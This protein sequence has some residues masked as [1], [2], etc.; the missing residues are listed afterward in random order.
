MGL[1]NGVVA[2]LV[3]VTLAIAMRRFGWNSFIGL[4]LAGASLYS[5]P[6]IIGFYAPLQHSLGERGIFAPTSAA[7][8]TLMAMVWMIFLFIVATL[9][10]PRS[11]PE[12]RMSHAGLHLRSCAILTVLGYLAVAMGQGL[13]FF[14][15]A[16]HEITLGLAATLW[17]WLPALGLVIAIASR[18][19]GYFSFFSFFLLIYFIAG[20]RTIPAIVTASSILVLFVKS[21]ER[22]SF[23]RPATLLVIS[24]LMAG[25]IFGKPIYLFIKNPSAEAMQVLF[26]AEMLRG[27][28]M[29]FEPLGT[30][31]LLEVALDARLQMDVSLFLLSI[32]GNA[33]MMPSLFGVNTNYFNEFITQSMPSGLTFGVAG[34]FFASAYVGLG[35]AGV[36]MLAVLFL[37]ALSVAERHA[38]RATGLTRIFLVVAGATLAIYAHRNGVDNVLSFL[39]QIII[40]TLAVAVVSKAQ[41]AVLPF[42]AP[43]PRVTR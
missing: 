29:A 30:Y 41:R 27:A 40:A 42:K 33:L 36:A 3:A 11:Y 8:V 32:F 31:S 13:L 1:Q 22:K 12:R 21:G 9:P 38:L 15:D 5:L 43:P 18:R 7:S 28:L 20:D 19:W 25:L 6:A 39:R 16:R 24:L 17:Q 2:V 14:L 35:F 10:V 4:G 23:P 37:I 34:N 26:S